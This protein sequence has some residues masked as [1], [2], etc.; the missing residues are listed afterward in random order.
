MEGRVHIKG[1]VGAASGRGLESPTMAIYTM[2]LLK[3]RYLP[4]P[5]GWM[6][7]QWQTSAEDLGGFPESLWSLVHIR[8]LKKPSSN[9]STTVAMR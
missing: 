7:Q 9:L 3:S 2:E 1:L 8:R 6:S 4:R 5:G